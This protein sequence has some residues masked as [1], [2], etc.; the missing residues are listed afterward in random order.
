MNNGKLFNL[1]ALG[2]LLYLSAWAGAWGM[3]DLASRSAVASMA[4]WERAGAMKD[5]GQWQSL[6]DS[7]RKAIW[8]NCLSSDYEFY[9]GKLFEWRSLSSSVWSSKSLDDRS[10]AMEYYRRAVAKR[11]SSSLAWMSLA[12]TRFLNQEL[13]RETFGALEKAM[14]FGPWDPVIQLKSI[15]IG[16]ALWK[17]LSRSKQDE[18]VA[19][20]KRSVTRPA[21]VKRIIVM[22]VQLD[23]ED[24]LRPILGDGWPGRRLEKLVRARDKRKK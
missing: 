8:L 11:P 19:V 1:A 12:K 2:A 15:W 10:Q 18:L 17:Q 6:S 7:V 20:I 9:M 22:A 13:D 21:L 3:A 23:R 24:V 4:R 14:V 5:N 16:L